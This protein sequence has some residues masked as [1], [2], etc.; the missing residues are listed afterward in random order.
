MQYLR[1]YTGDDGRSHLEEH[2]F[3]FSPAEFAPPAP[4]VDVSNRFDASAFMVIRASAGWTDPSHPA[5]ARQFMV[6]LSGSL[7][8]SAGADTRTLSPCDVILLEDTIGSGHAT[9]ALA[10][11]ILA[12]VRV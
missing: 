12:V 5:P 7:Q 6:L 4:P 1:L 8:V 9:T 11:V 10:D 2:E 3:T